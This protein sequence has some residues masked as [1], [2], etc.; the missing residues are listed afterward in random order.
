MPDFT[1]PLTK[2]LDA[3]RNVFHGKTATLSLL[4]H[5]RPGRKGYEVIWKV[6]GGWHLHGGKDIGSAMILEIAE[7]ETVT[8]ER[9]DQ[10]ECFAIFIPII[11]QPAKVWEIVDN[12]RMAPTYPSKRVWTFIVLPTGEDP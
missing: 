5:A 2:G 10:T 7:S 8:R 3:R 11:S 9:L 4:G 12:G 6:P 1:L